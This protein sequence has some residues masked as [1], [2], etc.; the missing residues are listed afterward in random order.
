MKSLVILVVLAGTL[1]EA[2]CGEARRRTAPDA[3]LRD[4]QGEVDGGRDE[5]DAAAMDTGESTDVGVSPDS[6]L[7]MADASIGD[8]GALV[9]SHSLPTGLSCSGVTTAR[10]TVRNTGDTT[11]T[12]DGNYALGAVNP[13]DVLLTAGDRV[14][15]GPAVAVAPGSEYTFDLVLSAPG[16][17]AYTTEWRMVRGGVRWFG[18]S[19]TSTVSVVCDGPFRVFPAVIDG[20]FDMPEHVQRVA[21]RD[22]SLVRLGH[23]ITGNDDIDNAVLGGGSPDGGIWLSGRFHFEIDAFGQNTSAS[24]ISVFSDEHYPVNGGIYPNGEI[25]MGSPAGLDISG[26]FKNGVVTGYVAEGGAII[27][28]GGDVWNALPVADQNYLR[29]IWHGADLSYVHGVMSGTGV[30]E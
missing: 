4:A 27:T 6:S 21:S 8:D 20:R 29:G 9:V 28:R 13:E 16:A 11:W 12:R 26:L 19:A 3:G 17:G 30:V 1:A 15:L 14:D 25:H 5:E 10:V 24:W 23:V 22:A 7:V 2:G 18:D